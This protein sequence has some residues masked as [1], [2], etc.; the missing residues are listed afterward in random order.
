MSGMET[1]P[2]HGMVVYRGVANS[3]G[4]P[5]EAGEPLYLTKYQVSKIGGRL[6]GREIYV[7][8]EYEEDG[9]QPGGRVL[10]SRL[11]DDGQLEVDFVLYNNAWGRG[12]RSKIEH[13]DPSQRM[14]GLSLGH[15]ILYEE[16]RG[17]K[18]GYP[19]LGNELT[20]LSVVR[21]GAVAGTGITTLM[22]LTQYRDEAASDQEQQRQRHHSQSQPRNQ[23]GRFAAMAEDKTPALKRKTPDPDEEPEDPQEPELPPAKKRAGAGLTLLREEVDTRVRD[24]RLNHRAEK[25]VEAALKAKVEEAKAA[26]GEHPSAETV[27]AL[28]GVPAPTAAVPAETAFQRELALAQQ[29]QEMRGMMRGLV[30]KFEQQQ[31]QQQ[32]SPPAATPEPSAP[33]APESSGELARLEKL[34]ALM[35]GSLVPELLAHRKREAREAREAI[36]D[37]VGPEDRA[38]INAH[39]DSLSRDPANP[40]NRDAFGAVKTLAVGASARSIKQANEIHKLEVRLAETNRDGKAMR[41]LLNEQQRKIEELTAEQSAGS[42]VNP[43]ESVPVVAVPV[44]ASAAT[45]AVQS[46]SPAQ[47][48]AVEELVSSGFSREEAAQMV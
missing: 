36:K 14:R 12:I 35:K 30:E 38:S 19:T 47:A 13:P 5:D 40:A 8:H 25:A 7:E 32:A 26:E 48:A 21:E 18:Q 3:A 39:L 6:K 31:Q 42:T 22:P 29:V 17:S 2:E 15:R 37:V 20:E 41:L 4:E 24:A 44:G 16:G 34:E 28:A 45:A 11:R 10:A 9:V 1:L 27:A 46:L 43:A 33:P 23:L